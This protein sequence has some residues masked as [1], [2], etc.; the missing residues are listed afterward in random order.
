MT[1]C[2]KDNSC[3][4]TYILK[5]LLQEK[6]VDSPVPMA[7]GVQ[8]YTY[9]V[10]TLNW[11]V[12]SYEDAVKGI[13][14][15]KHNPEEQLT[16]PAGVGEPYTYSTTPDDG[17]SPYESIGWMQMPISKHQQMVVAV[18]TQHRI[19]GYTA[20]E[21][22][23]NI[24]FYY[25]TV[26]FTPYKEA[27]QWKSGKWQFRN[28]YYAPPL[29]LKA[30][31]DPKYEAEQGGQP[32]AFENSEVKVYAYAADTLDWCVKS[33]EDAAAG[34]ITLKRDES[35]KRDQ[36]NFQAYKEQNGLFGMTINS[37]PVM[38]VV[39]DRAHK[40]YAYT[41]QEPDLAGECPT[42]DVLI[43]AWGEQWIWAANGWTLVNEAFSPEN[44]EP[45]P[46]PEPEPDPDVPD[47]NPQPEKPEPQ[48]ENPEQSETQPETQK[49]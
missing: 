40:I 15:S 3:A 14:T 26:V 47:P 30:Y 23:I 19:F 5:P 22:V 34:R 18:D 10:D 41:K 28:D 42:W 43:Q 39:V 1:G 2:L 8:L 35:E 45:E 29:K 33:F 36:P 37:S 6:Q 46:E 49:N 17:S 48:P 7:E 25:V 27:K 9:E 21:S 12:A 31:V 11:E 20:Q 16:Q 32:T 24:P 38:I 4:T 13:L 44:R